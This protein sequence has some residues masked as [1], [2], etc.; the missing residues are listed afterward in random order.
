MQVDFFFFF[1]FV[2][3]KK[4]GGAQN[5]VDWFAT[6][7]FFTPSLKFTAKKKL[8]FLLFVDKIPT[9]IK[10]EAPPPLTALPLRI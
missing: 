10:L 4:P 6:N 9:A 1:F 5:F 7:R 3:H 8:I 2:V